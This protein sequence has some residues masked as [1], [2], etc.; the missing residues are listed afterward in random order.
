MNE[1]RNNRIIFETLSQIRPIETALVSMWP[2]DNKYARIPFLRFRFKDIKKGDQLY[3][4][5]EEVISNYQGKIRWKLVV[6]SNEDVFNYILLPE[7]FASFFLEKRLTKKGD[8]LTIWTE[9]EYNDIIDSVI[10]DVQD[11]ANYMKQFF[12]VYFS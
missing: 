9:M 10:S 11:L 12:K 7:I 6:V 1:I 5:L 8:Y 2:L 3:L 4:K